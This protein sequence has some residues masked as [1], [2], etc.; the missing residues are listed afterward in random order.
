MRTEKDIGQVV[1]SWGYEDVEMLLSTITL[2]KEAGGTSK[3]LVPVYQ[4]TESFHIEHKATLRKCVK[5][6]SFCT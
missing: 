5:F 3:P 6:A 4:T 2:K 1:R